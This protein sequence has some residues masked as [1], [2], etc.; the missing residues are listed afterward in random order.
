VA[1]FKTTYHHF[2]RDSEEDCTVF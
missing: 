1:Y 2:P